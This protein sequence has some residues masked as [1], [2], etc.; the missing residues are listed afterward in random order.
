MEAITKTFLTIF[1]LL[2]V[3]FT[4]TGLIVASINANKAD[5]FLS[6]ATIGIEEGNFQP[7]IIGEWKQNAADIGYQLDTAA[8]DTNGD[9]YTDVVDLTLTYQY[10][11]PFL[12]SGASD[13]VLKSYAR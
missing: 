13:H 12:N 2:I 7:E 5:A 1:C 3:T 6:D 9:G 11:V 8:K 4:A 10:V